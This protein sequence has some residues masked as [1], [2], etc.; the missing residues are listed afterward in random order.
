MFKRFDRV[1]GSV[2]VLAGAATGILI[3]TFIERPIK[4]Y[5]F[6]VAKPKTQTVEED[7]GYGY[8]IRRHI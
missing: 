4:M 2:I 8:F 3:Y 7:V 5:L 6:P 1:P